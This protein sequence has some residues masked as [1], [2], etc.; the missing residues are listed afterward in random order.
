MPTLPAS[1]GKNY[2]F[3]EGTTAETAKKFLSKKGLSIRKQGAEPAAQTATRPYFDPQNPMAGVPSSSVP[4]G[5]FGR[6]IATQQTAKDVQAGAQTGSDILREGV[7]GAAVMAPFAAAAPFTGGT[8]IPA[9]AGIMGMAGLTGGALSQITDKI[10]GGENKSA[11]RIGGEIVMSGL[12]GGTQEL[13]LGT[14]IKYGGPALS[15]VLLR[16]ASKSAKGRSVLTDM[17]QEAYGALNEAVKGRNADPT[18]VYRRFL[19]MIDKIPV[20]EGPVVS[21]LAGKITGTVGELISQVRAAL[22][23]DPLVS[24]PE[25]PMELLIQMHSEAN[26][27]AFSPLKDVR[28]AARKGAEKFAND[29]RE[30]ITKNL[31]PAERKLFEAAKSIDKTQMDFSTGGAVARYLGRKLLVGS[32]GTIAGGGPLG[33]G[34]VAA[35]VAAQWVEQKAAPAILEHAITKNRAAY[36]KAIK[37]IRENPQDLPKIVSEMSSQLLKGIPT[38]TFNKLVE[39]AGDELFPKEAPDAAQAR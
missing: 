6:G 13:A 5:G 8:S 32:I 4:V 10:L 39:M 29:L 18:P 20:G 21:K 3:P 12:Y 9:G 11:G 17:T 26:Q 1:D 23:A 2:E 27:I 16:A 24:N 19:N 15:G 25:K 22:E 33:A 36:Q 7:A 31:N 14:A 30:L 34:A 28:A 35:D 37:L 38:R